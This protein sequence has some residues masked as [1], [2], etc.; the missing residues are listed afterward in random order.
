MKHCHFSILWNELP[1]LKQ[2][3][4][5]L[6]DNFD[7]LIFYDLNI[8]TLKYSDDGSHEFIKEYPDPQNKITLIEK[9]N[10]SDVNKYHGSSFVEKRRMFAVGSRHV[11]DNIG[12]FW[13]TDMDEFFNQSLI[14]KVE[15]AYKN[16]KKGTI[17]IPHL[18]YFKSQDFVF[19]DKNNNTNMWL[20]L[21]RI[22]RHKKGNIYGHCSLLSQF[23]PT[24]KIP[25]EPLHHYAYV[26]DERVKFKANIYIKYTPSMKNFYDNIWSTF[27]PSQ[28]E[29]GIYG[30]PNKPSGKPA[31]YM[32]PGKPWGIMRHD[33]KHPE[34]IN[35]PQM[36]EDLG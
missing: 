3:M 19:C 2:K 24:L 12:V 31:H 28:V 8:K 29:E 1:F 14:H 26:G 11:Q 30:C 6:Y 7:Q 23:T 35:I 33:Y 10:L 32:H 9:R 21:A 22:T 17:L 34:Y 25:S 13:C 18:I 20:P 16:G 36:I 4:K 27:D 15:S 5:F